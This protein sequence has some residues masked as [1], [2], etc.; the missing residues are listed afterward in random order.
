MSESK[1]RFLNNCFKIIDRLEEEGR[2]GRIGIRAFS[3]KKTFGILGTEPFS[4]KEM[5]IRD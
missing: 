1:K 2:I 3:P 5:G 4:R